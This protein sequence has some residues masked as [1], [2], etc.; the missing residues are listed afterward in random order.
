MC[1]SLSSAGRGIIAFASLAHNPFVVS[2]F[3]HG[4]EKEKEILITFEE[5][6]KGAHCYL[7]KFVVSNIHDS[8]EQK[9]E[10]IKRTFWQ[11]ASKIAQF[12]ILSP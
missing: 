4:Q 11:P 3:Q 5:C 12:F 6:G 2:N 9:S 1:C 7:R 10:I 8:T